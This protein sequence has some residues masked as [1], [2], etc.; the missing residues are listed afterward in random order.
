MATGP[1]N[2]PGNENILGGLLAIR[3]YAQAQLG[4]ETALAA[5]AA[6]RAWDQRGCQKWTEKHGQIVGL[7]D[8]PG[9]AED[10]GSQCKGYSQETEQQTPGCGV[11]ER[12]EYGWL[13][14][15]C[16]CLGSEETSG[17]SGCRETAMDR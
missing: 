17:Q 5:A 15:G 16:Q 6:G 14:Q 12:L 8:R 9:G 10:D 11:E 7:A 13:I 3:Q 2:D 1:V 4:R